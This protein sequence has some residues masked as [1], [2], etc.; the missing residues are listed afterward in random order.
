MISLTNK[1]KIALVLYTQG[2]DYDDR[3]RKEILSIK[4]LF[5]NVSFQIFAVEPNNREEKGITSYGTPYRIPYLKSRDKYTSGSHTLIK[6]LDFYRAIKKDLSSFDALWC[7]DIETFPFVL[8]SCGKPILWDLHEL[9]T[10]FFRNKLLR[11]FFRFLVWKC[12]VMVHANEPRLRVL[13][14]KKMVGKLDK[15]FYLRNYP[16]FNE[17]DSEYDDLYNQFIAWKGA[18]DCVYLQG[19]SEPTRAPFE[20]VDALLQST[21]LKCVIV[22]GFDDNAKCLLID[23]YKDVF[24]ERIFLTG[25]IKQIKTP[26]YIQACNFSMVF[27]KNTSENNY[28]CEANRLYQSLVNG[29][30]VLAGCNPPMKELVDCFNVGVALDSDGSNIDDI[31]KGIKKLLA[32]YDNYKLNTT[33]AKN[34]LM[35]NSQETIIKLFMDKYLNRLD[36]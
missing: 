36:K 22:G 23:K 18:D 16:Q 7:A 3:I 21:I 13:V 1:I 25:K 31:I 29:L 27:Y 4:K 35:W 19:L 17:I 20:T 34:A 30:P 5:P 12:D 32:N 33:T 24:S 14:E 6:A 15:Q 11:L 28:Y 8:F 9:P 10:F 2:L 26:Q